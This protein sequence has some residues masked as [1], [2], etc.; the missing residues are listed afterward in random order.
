MADVF[1]AK[2][3]LL[4]RPVAVKVLFPQF[5]A[6]ETFVIR[7]RREA[8]AAANLNHPNIVAV[9]DW[10]QHEDTYFIVM[11]YVEGQTLADLIASQGHLAPEQAAEVTSEVASALGFA[12][13]NGTV[14]RDVKPGNI[15][16]N[17]T[18]QVKVAD[19]GIARAL[20][21]TDD[22]LTQTGS[23]MGTASYFSPEQAQGRQVDP[24]SDLY[25]LGVV[26]Y[27]MLV[28]EPPFAGASPVAI[29]YKHV[30]ETP[31]RV[32]AKNPA[33]PSAL[34]QVVDCLLRK[35]PAERYPAAEELRADLRR[36]RE[37]VPLLGVGG[38]A[39]AA[40]AAAT[41]ATAAVS[42]SGVGGDTTIVAPAAQQAAAGQRAPI[43]D[44]VV[45]QQ[46]ATAAPG[47]P[48]GA[49]VQ[50]NG[51]AA[52]AM[53][54]DATTAMPADMNPAAGYQQPAA[55]V[56]GQGA[57]GG[58]N[59]LTDTGRSRAVIDTSRAVPASAAMGQ[60]EPVEEYY[61]PPS[62]TGVFVIMLG[63][64]LV[65]LVAL[66]LWLSTLLD[67]SGDT[68]EPAVNLIE[69]P[70]VVGKDGRDA[71]VEIRV[72]G[73]EFEQR[74]E[75]NPDVEF[76][77]AFAQEPAAGQ[78]VEEGSTVIVFLSRAPETEQVPELENVDVEVAEAQLE[79]L[80]LR[81]DRTF[82]ASDDI[83]EN[84]VIGTD[85]PAGT[86]VNADSLVTLIVSAG[87]DQVE[88]P[89]DVIGLE[90]LDAQNRLS[91]LKFRNLTFEFVGS[92]TVPE[93]R[94]VG[95]E[96]EAGTR[97]S[98]DSPVTVFISAGPQDVQIPLDLVGKS[99]DAAQSQ[100][101][102]DQLQL[103]PQFR[104]DPLPPDDPRIDQ[105]TRSNPAPGQFVKQGSIV[106]VFI[107]VAQEE[108]PTT[109]TTAEPNTETTQPTT[110]VTQPTSET[111]AAPTSDTSG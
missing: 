105:V 27:E 106:E 49:A 25:S 73:L 15:M 20:A 77:V 47:A 29:A 31:P 39:S 21:N 6:E 37:G 94:V 103:V 45:P 92:G 1:L 51:P 74:L 52:A 23:V 79:A 16:I 42:A 90:R 12:H 85:P 59:P 10:G 33:V 99:Q 65:V 8:Q 72:A 28:G 36:F 9:F 82:E 26:L 58:G 68:T 18:G 14:H 7:F 109:E 54:T 86:E 2:D 88:L 30:Q 96:P 35:D 38:A 89:A 81:A 53:G 97:V 56:P 32:K 75:V 34:D 108:A 61:E 111:T 55:G 78:E 22:E 83:L 44:P 98:I 57:A 95:L 102:D 70:D 50:T 93:N 17:R 46:P 19:F 4:D 71:E 100:L 104:N 80:G 66:I 60:A 87:P 69:V 24:R 76:N 41:G 62:R 48:H 67:G 3:Q 40:A 107:G 110:E 101:S 43:A 64:I 11:E 5:A 91:D 13:R 84:L 63:L